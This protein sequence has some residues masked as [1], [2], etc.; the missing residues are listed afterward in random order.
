MHWGQA[1]TGKLMDVVEPV[2]PIS[3]LASRA[4][5]APIAFP[6]P[7]KE[8][9]KRSPPAAVNPATKTSVPPCGTHWKQA[10]TG[11]FGELVLPV[12]TAFP[13]GSTAMPYP[14]SVPFPPR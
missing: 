7:Q 10:S 12:T 6:A 5:P 13:D 8:Q 1:A 11:R 14:I 2:I 3:S 4:I 9:K